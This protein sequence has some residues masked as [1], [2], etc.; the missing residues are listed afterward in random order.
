MSEAALSPALNIEPTCKSKKNMERKCNSTDSLHS[1]YEKLTS[2]S[3]NDS[4]HFSLTNSL[5]LKDDFCTSI[6]IVNDHEI[7]VTKLFGQKYTI[8]IRKLDDLALIINFDVEIGQ[9]T[10]FTK[11]EKY[12]FFGCVNGVLITDH[13]YK[14]K[15]IIYSRSRVYS[16]LKINESHLVLGQSCGYIEILNLKSMSIEVSKRIIGFGFINNLQLTR[17]PREIAISTS[18]GLYFGKLS[19]N[20]HTQESNF[21]LLPEKYFSELQISVIVEITKDVVAVVTTK[22]GLI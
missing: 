5:S 2:T 16:M 4:D 11:N 19:F 6:F 22:E 14:K 20:K 10:S 17:N 12:Y 1:L 18:R 3:V 15:S 8:D 21:V 7:A 13:N 9:P